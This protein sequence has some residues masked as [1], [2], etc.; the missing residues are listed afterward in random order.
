[1]RAIA[2]TVLVAMLGVM[3]PSPRPALADGAAST[4]NIILLGGAAAAYLII[5]HN[6]DVHAR[7]AAMAAQ[8]AQTAQAR[9]N[10]WAAYN[11]ERQAYL[12][13]LAANRALEQEVAYQHHVIVMEQSATGTPA[14]QRPSE[15]FVA[16]APSVV[17]G[18][19]NVSYGWGDV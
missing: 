18:I 10:A 17:A 9:D 19:A 5:K 13:Q 11:A 2:L 8:Q 4:R 16:G 6:H 12:Q 15:G 3:A 7:E 1:M 14:S